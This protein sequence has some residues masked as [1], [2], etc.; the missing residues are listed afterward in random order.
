MN[1]FNIYVEEAKK[2]LEDDLVFPAY[3]M[4]LKASHA[5]NVL[6]HVLGAVFAKDV[7][8]KTHSKEGLRHSHLEGDAVLLSVEQRALGHLLLVVTGQKSKALAK[9]LLDVSIHSGD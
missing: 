5:F 9:S 3:D 1:L 2:C 4:V 8:Y 7:P 6:C